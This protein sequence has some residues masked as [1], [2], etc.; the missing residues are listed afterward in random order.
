MGNVM[1][2][3]E[4]LSKNIRSEGRFSIGST[5]HKNM[6]IGLGL[7]GLRVRQAQLT[8][9]REGRV[10]FSNLPFSLIRFGCTNKGDLSKTRPGLFLRAPPEVKHRSALQ[11]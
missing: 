9:K 5:G 3:V 7:N 10:T 8:L 1:G 2:N 6:Y 11:K 4:W